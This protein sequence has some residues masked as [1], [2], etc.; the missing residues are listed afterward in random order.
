MHRLRAA[1]AAGVHDHA[2]V[3]I[4]LR[5]RGAADAHRLVRL[6]DVQRATIRLR[7][8]RH[9][10]ASHPPRGTDDAAGD[11]APVGDEDLVEGRVCMDQD[12]S[13]HVTGAPIF[14][15]WSITLQIFTASRRTP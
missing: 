4:A 11:L 12:R 13:P 8:H 7:V 1:H 14:T 15:A 5:R 6:L 9:G 3:Q 10:G 2:D